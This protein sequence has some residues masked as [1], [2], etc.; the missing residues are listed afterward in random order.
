MT[1]EEL[2]TFVHG[3]LTGYKKLHE[4]EFVEALPQ[5]LSGKI[6]RRELK[7]LERARRAGERVSFNSKRRTWPR[8]TGPCSGRRGTRV[9]EYSKASPPGLL[10][11]SGKKLLDEGRKFF[12]VRHK[13][14]MP[15]MVDVQLCIWDQLVHDLRVD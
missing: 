5:L 3:K 13:P 10:R 4:V 6:L 7:E 11:I 1:D 8:S 12:G 9:W 14:Q 2:V 15:A